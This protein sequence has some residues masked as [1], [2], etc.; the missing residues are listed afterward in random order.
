MTTS[1]GAVDAEAC[2]WLTRV[3]F[4]DQVI[5]FN[6]AQELLAH[7]DLHADFVALF[8]GAGIVSGPFWEVMNASLLSMNGS[9]HRRMRGHVASWFTPRAVEG[10]RPETARAAAELTGP[11]ATGGTH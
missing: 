6:E 9:E 4:F 8:E 3:G 2:P 11:L 7:P 10:V 1:E 5:G